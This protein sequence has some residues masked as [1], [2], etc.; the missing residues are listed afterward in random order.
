[1]TDCI[2]AAISGKFPE[3]ELPSVGSTV[4]GIFTVILCPVCGEKTLDNHT[5]CPACGWEYDGFPEYHYS[6]ANG[7]TLE[8]YRRMYFQELSKTG[9]KN[10]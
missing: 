6:A 4:D 10:V 8:N 9:G 2:L 1:M 3:R 7:A 5:V